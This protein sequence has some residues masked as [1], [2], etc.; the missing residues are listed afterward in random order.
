MTTS[1]TWIL[2]ADGA[3]ARL[4]SAEGRRKALHVVEKLELQADHRPTHELERDRPTRV[5]EAHGS[6]RHAVEP[7]SDPHRELKRD[8]AEQIAV[9]LDENLKKG[10]FEKL[11]VAAAPVT[12]G[13]LRKAMSAAVKDSVVAEV[14]MD[15]TKV[16]NSDV[17][18]HIED[19][20]P[21]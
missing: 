9:V 8:F 2:I 7:K 21:L 13:D 11:V 16:P 6:A 4:L 20:V 3:R 12:L 17:P 1:K 19:V 18:Q 15:L 10:N 5:Y 14:A